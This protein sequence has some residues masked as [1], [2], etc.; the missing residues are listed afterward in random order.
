MTC[1]PVTSTWMPLNVWLGWRLPPLLPKNSVPVGAGT[2][3]VAPGG[4]G[5]AVTNAAPKAAMRVYDPISIALGT[6]Y[7]CLSVFLRF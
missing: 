3:E 6:L 7:M 1:P 5:L 2:A 4:Y